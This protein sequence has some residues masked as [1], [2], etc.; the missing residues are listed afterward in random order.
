MGWSPVLCSE[1]PVIGCRVFETLFWMNGW[2]ELNRR[3][4]YKL[5]Y[6]P[7][8]C[9]HF[10][11]FSFLNFYS[12]PKSPNIV[13]SIFLTSQFPYCVTALQLVG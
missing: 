8:C 10:L 13:I 3:K 4:Y 9:S 1:F 12:D 6:N 5:L 7:R 11:S 2:I